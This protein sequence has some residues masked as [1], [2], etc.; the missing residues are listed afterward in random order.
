MTGDFTKKKVAVYK[1][2]MPVDGDDAADEGGRAE[3]GAEKT[4]CKEQA[5]KTEVGMEVGPW[6]G[7]SD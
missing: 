4:E 3:E 7:A 5:N 6:L 2:K 1:S